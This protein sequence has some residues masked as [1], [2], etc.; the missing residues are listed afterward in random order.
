MHTGAKR[1]RKDRKL[2]RKW[3]DFSQESREKIGSY[4]E[5]QGMPNPFDLE[6]PTP[7]EVR[8]WVDEGTLP[9]VKG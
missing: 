3:V 5:G 7:Q 9:S 8:A 2:T 4:A 1:N 6:P